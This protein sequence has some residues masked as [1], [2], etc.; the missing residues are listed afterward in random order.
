[1]L[2]I[3][4][5]I[6]GDEICCG[7]VRD[8]NG[9]WLATR[10]SECGASLEWMLFL[11]DNREDVVAALNFVAPRVDGVV[12]SGGL[13]PTEDDV[14]AEAV[15]QWAGRPLQYSEVHEAF[16][17]N[18][19]RVWNNAQKKQAYI[20]QGAVRIHSPH[21]TACPFK[22]SLPASG[23]KSLRLVSLPGVPKE[24]QELWKTDVQAYLLGE[25]SHPEI[26]DRWFTFGCGEAQLQEL[27]SHA[28][29]GLSVRPSLGF[30]ITPQG[31]EVKLREPSTAQNK[32]ARD[33]LDK[34]LEDFTYSKQ[35]PHLEKICGEL[36]RQRKWPIAIAESCTGGL[37]TQLLT[38]VPGVSE[39]LL[40]G[41][42]SYSDRWKTDFVGV[43]PELIKGYGAV[44][45]EVVKAMC[46]GLE[47]KSPLANILISISGIAGPDGGTPQKPV[48]TVWIGL[49]PKGKSAQ[50]HHFR[51]YGPRI[52]IQRRAAQAALFLL[53][54]SLR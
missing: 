17:K 38:R 22:L 7:E 19:V 51:F 13:G 4:A 27:C 45:E 48:G 46:E 53:W 8:A 52:A 42:V 40:G 36:L 49:K 39:V 54:K 50:A 44:S 6:I 10:L 18:Q 21:G 31:V 34:T 47:H 26:F 1:M 29:S 24:F 37:L 43:D 35:E 30:L 2:K 33:M 41:V 15:A 12:L 23:G 20:P 16:L 3:G 32:L 11:N 14:T 5:L 9:S 25:T 28:L